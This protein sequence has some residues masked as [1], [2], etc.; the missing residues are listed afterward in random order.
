MLAKFQTPY[1]GP[2]AIVRGAVR[3]EKRKR[4]LS[5]VAVPKTLARGSPDCYF[6]SMLRLRHLGHL[7]LAL[8]LAMGV[9]TY[10]AQATGMDGKMSMAASAMHMCD[11][12]DCSTGGSEP[13]KSQGTCALLCSGVIGL[14]ATTAVLD[15]P[16]AA[17]APDGTIRV[18]P[19]WSAPPD[20]YPP[21]LS[22]LS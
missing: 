12:G 5:V 17:T 7:L 13:C 9:V 10:A 20:P 3:P 2:A 14:P 19:G 18:G 1:S 8:A 15:V 6:G 4:L 11:Q 16:P 21:R 22:V